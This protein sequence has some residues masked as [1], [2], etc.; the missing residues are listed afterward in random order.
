[1]RFYD[2]LRQRLMTPI[3]PG[4]FAKQ[5]HLPKTAQTLGG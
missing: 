4:A 1:M 3:V 5:A 2:N